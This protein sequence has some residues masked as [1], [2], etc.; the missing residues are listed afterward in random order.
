M[1]GPSNFD[2]DASRIL[3][4][5]VSSL[6]TLT[7]ERAIGFP[8]T[9]EEETIV[10]AGKR[11]KLIVFRQPGPEEL[12]DSILITVLLSR[13][14]LLGIT[15]YHTERGLLFSPANPVREATDMELLQNG[16]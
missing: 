16:G 6:R 1:V 3:E 7:Y 14:G 12:T 11:C 5:R 15:Q 10:V 2:I 8:E 4:E 13:S 9:S